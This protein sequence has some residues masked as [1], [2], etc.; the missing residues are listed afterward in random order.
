M[1]FY[2]DRVDGPVHAIEFVV[3][4]DG[5][6]LS[7]VNPIH[8][9]GVPQTKLRSHIK[10]V[11][12]VLKAQFGQDMRVS[13]SRQPASQCPLCQQSREGADE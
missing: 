3:V 6:T 12:G 8:L 1:I 7:R 10:N 5:Q 4:K 13:Q 11:L 2:R 9:K